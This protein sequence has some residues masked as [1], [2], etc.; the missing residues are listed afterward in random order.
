[1]GVTTKGGRKLSDADI[2]RLAEQ[3]EE[4]FDL[5]TW[6]PRRGRPSL[7]GDAGDSPRVSVRVPPTTHAKALARARAEGQTLSDVLRAA[8]EAYAAG[9]P[10]PR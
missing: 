8:L 3:A 6:S 1:M 10:G 2:E 7:G 5:S 9:G 4:G